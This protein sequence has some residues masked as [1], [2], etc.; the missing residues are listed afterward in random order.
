MLAL[1]LFSKQPALILPV[2]LLHHHHHSFSFSYIPPASQE[3]RL[4]WYRLII[5]PQTVDIQHLCT[6]CEVYLHRRTADL[7][8]PQNTFQRLISQ[9]LSFHT[10]LQTLCF[11]K[12]HRII[13]S[14]IIRHPREI[15][16]AASVIARS[17]SCR[18]SMLHWGCFVFEQSTTSLLSSVVVHVMPRL[19]HGE[20]L[21]RMP[22][23]ISR[24][25]YWNMTGTTKSRVIEDCRAWRD[26]EKGVSSGSFGWIRLCCMFLVGIETQSMRFFFANSTLPI[27]PSFSLCLCFYTC[28]LSDRIK[29]VSSYQWGSRKI[30]WVVHSS[31]KDANAQCCVTH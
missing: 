7:Q 28:K 15:T 25:A 20:D 14:G 16:A 29:I 10:L 21:C 9:F 17:S 4:W 30:N 3:F 2:L 22:C 23:L 1:V 12:S 18:L 13:P 5:K 8:L 24:T 19:T 31:S 11:A 6:F 26:T 27:L